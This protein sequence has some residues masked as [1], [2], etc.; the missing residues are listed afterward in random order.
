MHN[1]YTHGANMCSCPEWL[2][3]LAYKHTQQDVTHL[4]LV[5]APND[6]TAS[7]AA[8]ES[9]NMP[10]NWHVTEIVRDDASD[11]LAQAV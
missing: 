9:R 2:V 1:C 5:R 6:L 11:M 10:N 7:R 4:E 8:L 3:E